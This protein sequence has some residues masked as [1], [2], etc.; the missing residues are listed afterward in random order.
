MLYNKSV[1]SSSCIA[2]A[3][4]FGL[5]ILT[6]YPALSTMPNLTLDNLSTSFTEAFLLTLSFS[7]Q[8]TST[9]QEIFS[10]PLCK[11]SVWFFPTHLPNRLTDC[12]LARSHSNR[13]GA[14][15]RTVD[16]SFA[17]S[18]EEK[19]TTWAEASPGS[20]THTIHSQ[21]IQPPDS[22]K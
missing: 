14:N 22:Y 11:G 21:H 18:E 20:H 6:S 1:S 9:G 2:F 7:P 12:Y 3:S 8:R 10:R 17:V 4:P 15:I 19:N 13:G 5:S 16:F